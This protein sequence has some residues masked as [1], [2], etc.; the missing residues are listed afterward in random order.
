VCWLPSETLDAYCGR[1]LKLKVALIYALTISLG[2]PRLLCLHERSL[3]G[4]EK[5]ARNGGKNRVR[6]RT[7]RTLQRER[8]GA[9][10]GCC[11]CCC[12]GRRCNS[13]KTVLKLIVPAKKCRQ[14]EELHNKQATQA[15]QTTPLCNFLGENE[16][17]VKLV[18]QI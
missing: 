17:K 1:Q 10:Y 9:T 18:M 11:C 5:R 8:V 4:A 15:A 13:I 12:R 2:K 3:H 16:K 7:Q 14:A 6:E